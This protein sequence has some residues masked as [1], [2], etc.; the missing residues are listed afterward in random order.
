MSSSAHVYRVHPAI[1]VTRVGNSEEYYLAPETMA[2]FPQE[3]SNTTGGLP[4][5][6]GTESESI[7]SCDLRDRA[8]ALK[9]QAARFRIFQYPN[10]LYETYPTGE[11]T[12]ITVG[13][14]VDG[15]KVTDII[16][17]V[18]LAN[19]KANAYVL[20]DDLGMQIYDP[21]HTADL[22]IR[23][24]AQGPDLD[25]AA[26]LRRLVID[27]GPRAI[28]ATD[29]TAVRFDKPTLA[30]FWDSG[31]QI[32]ELALYPKS[33]PDDNFTPLYTPV[34][35]IETLG[36]L[37]TDDQ[38]R[39]VVLSGYGK[40]CGWC[41]PD[42]TPYTLSGDQIVPGVYG[43]VN[44]DGWFDDTSD[45]PV[46]ATLVFEDGSVQEAHGAWV[47][48][49]AP[50][51]AP[52]ILNV[53]SM[54][55][56]IYNSWVRKLNLVP[57]LFKNRFQD[58]YQPSF[59]DHLNPIFL[60]V[61]LQ[62]WTTNLPDRAITSH[63]AV[64]QIKA[65]DDPGETILT[66]LAYIRDP[67]RQEQFGVGAPFMPLSMGDASKAFLTVSLTQY[68][69]LSQWNKGLFHRGGGRQLGPGES[70]DKASLVNCLGGR[71]DPGIEMSFIM[72]DPEIYIDD[73]ETS[74]GGPFRL[75]KRPLDYNR[76]QYSHPFLTVG[77]IPMHPGPDGVRPAPMEPGDVT[78]FMAIPWHS[79]YSACATHNQAPNP[80]NSS[81]LYWSWPAQRPVQIH[82]AKDVC[83]G[84]L[85]PLLYSVRGAGTYSDDPGL[86][87]RYQDLINMVLNWYKIGVVIQG[88]AIEGDVAYSPEQYL[89]VESQLDEPEITPWPMNSIAIGT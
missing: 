36:E 70:L 20:N 80:T 22:L 10:K 78:K 61:A 50:G 44:G 2:G 38:G 39:L 7:T 46:E 51:Y 71:L 27:P 8:G 73:W 41:H 54:W 29:N 18:H 5:R 12:E 23:N 24:S 11:G 49:A 43:D 69:F 62:R 31:D 19:K 6:A 35:K 58:S 9:R 48:S 47:I 87:G 1:G 3:G 65:T 82:A 63:D 28:R 64:G 88:S 56:D 67:N 89:E 52:Q 72:R 79:D 55:D 85:G 81:T 17:T 40:A 32:K 33:F 76:A 26:R 74:G 14:V 15:K 42:G 84:E 68:F 59:E 34:G 13:S 21:A 4:I 86:S 30:S 60:A 75:R 83:D 77:Y 16:W 37:R 53:V 45:G 25:N 66:G 57:R